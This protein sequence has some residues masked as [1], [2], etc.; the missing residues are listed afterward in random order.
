M[1]KIRNAQAKVHA[2]LIARNHRG[3]SAEYA[4]LITLAII[5]IALLFRPLRDVFSNLATKLTNFNS[6]ATNGTNTP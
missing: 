4:L 3:M 5:V 6:D 2:A 1:K